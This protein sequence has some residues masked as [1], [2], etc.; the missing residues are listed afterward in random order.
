MDFPITKRIKITKSIK[1]INIA[2][3]QKVKEQGTNVTLN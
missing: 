2:K 1:N 3:R